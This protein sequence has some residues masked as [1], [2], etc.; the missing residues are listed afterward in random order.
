MVDQESSIVH[1]TSKSHNEYL[2]IDRNNI[3]FIQANDN[4]VTIHF[5]DQGD[6]KRRMLRNTLKDIENQLASPIVKCHRSYL[7]NSN[8]IQEIFGNMNN[9]KL[10]LDGFNGEIP[11]SRSY[12]KA[13]KK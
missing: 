9:S 1:L 3:L 8:R 12:V 11:V 6:V 5:L 2:T 4:Y 13:F 7:V 10:V